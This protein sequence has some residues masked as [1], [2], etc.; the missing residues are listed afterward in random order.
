MIV[1][2]TAP[3]GVDDVIKTICEKNKILNNFF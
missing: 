1:A 2:T 3:H